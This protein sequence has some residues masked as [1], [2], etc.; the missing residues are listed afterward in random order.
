[1]LFFQG[2]EIEIFVQLLFPLQRWRFISEKLF[3]IPRW[4]EWH[5]LRAFCFPRPESA[6]IFQ[7]SSFM[8]WITVKLFLLGVFCCCCLMTV[9]FY[10]YLFMTRK[11]GRNRCFH[12]LPRDRDQ[13]LDLCALKRFLSFLGVKNVDMT[14]SL[15]KKRK[16]KKIKYSTSEE[17][18]G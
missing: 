11:N 9:S 6:Y 4:A 13:F 1:M 7:E 5:S 14:I 16:H 3:K 18:A 2:T 15:N 10:Q 17:I 8:N 12:L